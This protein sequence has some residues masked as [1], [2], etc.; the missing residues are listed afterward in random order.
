M[1]AGNVAIAADEIQ[2]TVLPVDYW[3]GAYVGI[4]GGFGFGTGDFSDQKF[5]TGFGSIDV[6]GFDIGVFGGYDYKFDDFV[7]GVSAAA[8]VDNVDGSG[9]LQSVDWCSL[10]ACGGGAS[11][12]SD[13]WDL[14]VDYSL[15]AGFRGGV[16]LDDRTLL[17]A[18]GGV[19]VARA[20][21]K[22]TNAV[23]G[24]TYNPALGFPLNFDRTHV[25]YYIGGGAEYAISKR[26]HVRGEFTYSDYGSETYG[27]PGAIPVGEIDLEMFNTRLG[28]S[29]SF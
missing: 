25:G 8:N 14:S 5:P 26:F 27:N 7:L 22:N 10:L 9:S 24:G 4:H 6:D 17:F 18:T 28:V 20:N 29:V 23:I 19:A 13:I 12:N 21:L 15:S 2:D 3:T 11:G 16:L 1:T